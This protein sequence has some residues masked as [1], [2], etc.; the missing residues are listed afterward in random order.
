MRASD[1]GT[2]S[3]R[4]LSL[5]LVLINVGLGL[6]ALLLER[7]NGA[8]HVD[9][10]LALDRGA[11]WR[12]TTA[13]SVNSNAGHGSDG[14]ELATSRWREAGGNSPLALAKGVL[15]PVAI[16]QAACLALGLG[17]SSEEE[18]ADDGK[19]DESRDGSDVGLH[20]AVCFGLVWV[21]VVGGRSKS[22]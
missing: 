14:D 16:F 1:D 18:G 20:L 9:S 6:D 7:R 8:Q 5:H 21:V 3:W 13:L 15:L 4:D 10:R 2:H 22:G 17:A 19:E 12:V 11:S